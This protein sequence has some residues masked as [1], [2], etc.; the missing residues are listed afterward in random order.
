MKPLLTIIIPCYNCRETLEE[1]VNSCYLQDLQEP[2]EIILVDDCSTDNT[3]EIMK[4]MSGKYRE[5]RLFYHDKNKGGGAT[6]NT[7]ISHADGELIFCVD[8][9]DILPQGT[10]KKMI[11]F[12]REKKCDGVAI[13]K[14]IKFNGRDRNNID[15]IDT[16]GYVGEKIPFESV[17]ESRTSQLCPLYYVFLYTKKA[18]VITGGY[19]EDHGFDTQGFAWRFLSKKLVAYTCPDASYL[20]RVHFNASYYLR[21]QYSGRVNYNWQKILEEVLYFFNETAIESI[22]SFDVRNPTKSILIELEKIDTLLISNDMDAKDVM[23]VNID[24]C[25]PLLLYWAGNEYMRTSQFEKALGFFKKAKECGFHY[26]IVDRKIFIC[27]TAKAKGLGYIEAEKKF[28]KRYL[29]SAYHPISIY[30]RIVKKLFI[31]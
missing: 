21:E 4:T 13:H 12:W 3:R 29:R 16:F 14:S 8:S 17:F 11:N 23:S 27:Q 2:F 7:A 28:S 5:V 15:R 30:F 20:H 24:D 10:L 18:F 31:K 22:L 9:D 25:E 19:P 1:A 6:R 26:R